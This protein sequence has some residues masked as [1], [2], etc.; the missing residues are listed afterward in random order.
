[1]SWGDYIYADDEYIY[2]DDGSAT[3]GGA[4]GGS[5]PVVTDTDTGSGLPTDTGSGGSDRE[6]VAMSLADLYGE[7]GAP[8]WMS[9]S[10]AYQALMTTAATGPRTLDNQ[11][12]KQEGSLLKRIEDFTQKNK[13]LTELV[14]RGVGSAIQGRGAAKGRENELRV[15]NDLKQADNARISASV[16]GLRKPGLIGRQMPLR[17][18]DGTPVYN[19]GR[20]V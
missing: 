6:D 7:G 16:S 9:S 14:L 11:T 13:G 3:D 8:L 15:A 4:G 19:A 2:T 20:A 1:M 17:R 10:P 18:I 12:P 5:T